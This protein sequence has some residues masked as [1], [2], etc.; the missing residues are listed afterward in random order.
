MLRT[1]PLAGGPGGRPAAVPADSSHAAAFVAGASRLQGGAVLVR[2]ARPPLAPPGP[3]RRAALPRRDRRGRRVDPGGGVRGHPIRSRPRSESAWRSRRPTARGCWPGHPRPSRSGRNASGS[4]AGGGSVERHL[5]RFRG[6]GR[7]VSVFD[8]VAVPPDRLAPRAANGSSGSSRPRTSPGPSTPTPARDACGSGRSSTCRDPAD[9]EALEPLATQVYDIVLDAGGTISSSRACGL[10]R[11]QFLRKQ[12]GELVQVFREI[13]DAFDPMDQ[14]N[15]G[16]VIGDDPHLMIRDLRTIP[17]C[18]DVPGAEAARR[19]RGAGPPKSAG[20]PSRRRPRHAAE[21]GSGVRRTIRHPA[22][23]SVAPAGPDLARAGDAR[24]GVGLPWLRQSAGSIDPALRMCPSFRASRMEAASPRSQANLIRQVATGAVDPRLWGSDELKA[25]ADL[26]IHCKLC[27]SECPSGVDV[28][29]LM[30]EA[31]AAYVEK[32]GLPPGDWIFS[33]LELWARLGSRL[34][35]VTNFLLTRRWSRAAAGAAAGRLAA[36]RAAARPAD[37]VHP[38]RRPAG[39]EQAP[40]AAARPAG[41]LLRRR[42]RQLLRPGAGRGGRRRPPPRRGQRL[43]ARRSSAARAWP[44]SS[45]ATSIM[46]ATRPW[47]TSACWPTPCATATPSSAP[48][49]PPR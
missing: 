49:R 22:A 41:R 12:F 9:R 8:D 48:S 43:R 1:V 31:K 5:M 24:D 44:R 33:R 36:P 17:A 11:T 38:P 29:S 39:P 18:R 3:R 28:S 34:P 15:P 20:R 23:D 45:S 42:L 40:A 13:K 32:H 19:S 37:P 35:I 30:L 21:A 27:Q 10:V 46:R 2:P 6:P 47:R 26:C 7:P 25:H 16:K 14:L 4:W